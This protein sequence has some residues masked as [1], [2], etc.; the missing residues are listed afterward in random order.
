MKKEYAGFKCLENKDIPDCCGSCDNY[1]RSIG[2]YCSYLQS[3]VHYFQYCK[4]GYKRDLKHK[5]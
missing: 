2:E 1:Y 5:D 3:T 4:E